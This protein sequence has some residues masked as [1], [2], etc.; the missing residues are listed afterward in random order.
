MSDTHCFI[1]EKSGV[2]QIVLLPAHEAQ[3]HH[4]CIWDALLA[5]GFLTAFVSLIF[6]LAH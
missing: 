5:V 6:L 2:D 1:R 3:P 4:F